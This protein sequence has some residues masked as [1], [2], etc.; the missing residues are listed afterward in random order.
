MEPLSKLQHAGVLTV[1]KLNPKKF[2][3]VPQH[4]W[5][6]GVKGGAHKALLFVY[7]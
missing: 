5:E 6:P 3:I 2:H 7:V 4:E 1:C